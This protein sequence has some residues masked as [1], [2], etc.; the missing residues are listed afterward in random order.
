M[1]KVIG[2]RPIGWHVYAMLTRYL[3]AL[4][5]WFFCRQIWPKHRIESVA[6]ALLFLVYPGILQE[7]RGFTF[8]TIWVQLALSIFSLALMVKAVRIK[9]YNLVVIT[10]AILSAGVSWNISEYFLGFELLRPFVLYLAVSD[11]PKK[12]LYKALV[13]VKWWS[14]YLGALL[15]YVVYRLFVF[16]TKRTEVDP[17][18]FLS[19]IFSDPVSEIVLRLNFVIPDLIETSLL[20]WANTLSPENLSITARSTWLAWMIGAVVI[21]L[22]H[23]LLNNLKSKFDDESAREQKQINGWPLLAILVGSLR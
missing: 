7:S 15:A 11:Q 17:N 12:I 19:E 2:D 6:V 5:L 23:F 22:A 21:V 10:I 20:V 4:A 14:L 1:H 16:N 18:H 8:G 9:N 3:S 13:A